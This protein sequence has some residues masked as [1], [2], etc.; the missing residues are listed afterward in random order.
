M[1]REAQAGAGLG[2]V[3]PLADRRQRLPDRPQRLGG[4]RVPPGID[5]DDLDRKQRQESAQ[6]LVAPEDRLRTDR[7]AHPQTSEHGGQGLSGRFQTQHGPH[8]VVGRERALHLAG[9]VPDRPG[10]ADRPAAVDL[11]DLD[12]QEAVEGRAL[13]AAAPAGSGPRRRSRS[14]A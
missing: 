4:E 14:R 13:L 9:Q 8:D 6:L 1:D 11:E 7:P 2:E 5:A 3:L 10:A 12:L